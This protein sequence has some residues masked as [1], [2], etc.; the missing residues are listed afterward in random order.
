MEKLSLCFNGNDFANFVSFV[1]SM[2][3]R[4]KSRAQRAVLLHVE[5]NYLVC[6]AID[7]A[8]NFLEYKVD[9]CN[10]CEN[11]I[12]EQFAVSI[13]DLAALIKCSESNSFSIRKSFNQ[14][15][16]NVIGNGWLPFNT[17]DVDYDRYN[18]SGIETEIGKIN[19][20]KL[21]TAI[22][23][24]LGYTQEYTYARDKYIQ[25]SKT[26]MVVTSRLSS[27]IT[28]DDF[29]DMTL[30]RDDAALLKSLLKDDGDI[31]VVKI[32]GDVE[33]LAFVNNKFK[34]IVIAAGIDQPS[35]NYI[36]NIN[37]YMSID[38]NELYKLAAF[39]EE[40]PASKHIV[41]IKIKDGKF[42][43][44][45]KNILAAK[46]TSIINATCHGDVSD[47]KEAEVPAH[48]LL[49]SLK[50]FQDKRSRDINIYLTDEMLEKQNSIVLFDENTQAIINIYNR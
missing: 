44:N 10:D 31:S 39:S 5:D 37:N 46:H 13:T 43:V 19:S 23:S 6:R 49:K 4:D 20:A 28:H 33:R 47:T 34:F 40:Y 29:V 24:V 38:C 17:V 25:F 12:T 11:S 48:S 15:E 1:K 42:C 45:V 21:R 30:H 22:S 14:F 35:A 3:S 16:F 7:D 27:V 36:E 26:Q 2:N 18:I 9:L 32:E 50:L 8:S 41:G